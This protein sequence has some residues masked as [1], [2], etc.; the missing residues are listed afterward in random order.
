MWKT[1]MRKGFW[2][3]WASP[4]LMNCF[5]LNALW[6]PWEPDGAEEKRQWEEGRGGGW[7]TLIPL[8]KGIWQQC[9]TAGLSPEHSQGLVLSC[10]GCL[11]H[12][13]CSSCPEWILLSLSGMW[14]CFFQTV[15]YVYKQSE[16][17]E[18]DA[19]SPQSQLTIGNSCPTRDAGGERK[20]PLSLPHFPGL[21]PAENPKLLST[22]LS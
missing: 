22:T 2:I 5:F 6:F 20:N 9:G 14:R 10:L 21:F 7:R 13:P 15:I 4:T 17:A 3:S 18:K 8:W 1:L 12:C 11:T 16:N 19:S